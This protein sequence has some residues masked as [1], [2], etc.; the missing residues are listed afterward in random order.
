MFRVK[1]QGRYDT[2]FLL[3]ELQR[4]AIR[5]KRLVTSGMRIYQIQLA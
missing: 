2:M 5:P 3:E 4:R 1:I